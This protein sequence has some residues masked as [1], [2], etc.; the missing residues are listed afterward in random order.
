MEIEWVAIGPLGQPRIERAAR[1]GTARFNLIQHS[2]ERGSIP[3]PLF[4]IYP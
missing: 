3:P 2:I 1:L 4:V